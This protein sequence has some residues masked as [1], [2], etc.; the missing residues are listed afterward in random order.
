M[1]ISGKMQ[2]HGSN[3]RGQRIIIKRQG[4]EVI[5]SQKFKTKVTFAIGTAKTNKGLYSVR[6]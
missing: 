3:L 4:R 1:V 6:L 5:P 2:G